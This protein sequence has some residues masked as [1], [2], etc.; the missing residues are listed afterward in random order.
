LWQLKKRLQNPQR[1]R[2][3]SVIEEKK[4]IEKHLKNRGEK[5]TAEN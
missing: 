5:E 3:K 1:M 2:L 4:N